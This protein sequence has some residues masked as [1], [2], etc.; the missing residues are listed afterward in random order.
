MAV[1]RMETIDSPAPGP[2]ST[3]GPARSDGRTAAD[4]SAVR[5]R[6]PRI[7]IGLVWG[8]IDD[9]AA[10][11]EAGCP[12]DAVAVGHYAGVAPAGAERALDERI[13]RKRRPR[14]PPAGE[15]GLLLTDL[16]ARGV[17]RGELGQAFFLPD[18]R[19]AGAGGNRLI[20]V[21]GMGVPG[22]FGEGELAVLA[23]ELCWSLGRLGRRHLAT[24][25]LGAGEGNLSVDQAVRGWVRGITLALTGTEPGDG[26]HL[27]RVSFVERDPRR[28][29]AIRDA[30]LGHKAELSRRARLD[31]GYRG[32]SADELAS[33][34]HARAI[35][36][37]DRASWHQWRALR[38]GPDPSAPVRLIVSR[39]GAAY[40]F[41]ALTSTASVPEREVRLDPRLVEQANQELAT[42][43]DRATQH[44][45]GRFLERLLI[46]GDL[47]P[48]L[49]GAAPLVLLVDADTARIHWEL[50][51]S[52]D[53]GERDR[54]QGPDG[55]RA[56]MDDAGQ[57]FLG[58]TRGLT[59]QLR[60][61]F[62]PPPQPPPAPR[63]LLRVLVVADP[64]SD[65]P[66]PGARQEGDDVADLFE[67]FN[68]AWAHTGNE[69]RVVRLLGP[70][71]ATRSNVLR[72]LMLH[73]YDVLHYAGHCHYDPA[74]AGTCGWVFSGGACLSVRELTRL[75]RVPALVFSNACQSAITTV[76]T[77]EAAAE[78]P[79][80]TPAEEMAGRAEG[81]APGFA[82]AFFD[83]GV[84][85]FVGTAWAVDDAI[86]RR[87]A[88]TVYE[89]LLGLPG[90]SAATTKPVT[91]APVPMHEA[92]RRARVETS[93]WP[94]GVRNWGA[95]QHYGDANLTL[96]DPVSLRPPGTRPDLRAVET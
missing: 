73:T 28:L 59:R 65:A 58:T 31:I 39:Q 18:P 60:T 78:G 87:F 79:A 64:S 53:P 41:G 20:A 75:D 76:A 86:A 57:Y 89:S 77:T 95:Y 13:S 74:S 11:V 16:A 21:V 56:P 7:E 40:R 1:T 33:P 48:G 83:R 3:S 32:V 9:P 55:A 72:H 5:A 54:D 63:R 93:Q 70:A 51:A 12:V 45:R 84:A 68:E 4:P 90:A 71:Q 17:I 92:M 94:G 8:A 43:G 50:L 47:R 36:R 19:P 35:A 91:A 49:A 61:S 81:L 2:A 96:F 22:R 44:D 27:R 80:D 42:E 37:L 88:L 26:S 24:V 38:G 23:R 34:R 25:L 85:N 66:L 69:V 30:I 6:S 10:V 14:Q 29:A 67:R 82:E 62:A 15:R 46:P 52:T